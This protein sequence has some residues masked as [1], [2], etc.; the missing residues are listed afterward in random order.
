MIKYQ[1]FWNI[2]NSWDVMD[3]YCTCRYIRFDYI[4]VLNTNGA[5]ASILGSYLGDILLGELVFSINTNIFVGAVLSILMVG[6]RYHDTHMLQA[7]LNHS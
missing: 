3:G 1:T 7:G 6:C 5:G 2:F 4:K